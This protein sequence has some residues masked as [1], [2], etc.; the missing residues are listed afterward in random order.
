MM[1]VARRLPRVSDTTSDKNGHLSREA[2][3]LY[4]DVGT[5]P[6]HIRLWVDQSQYATL[7]KGFGCL[8]DRVNPLPTSSL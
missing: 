6:T 2:F 1:T 7:H 4:L 8:R 5:H 3:Y